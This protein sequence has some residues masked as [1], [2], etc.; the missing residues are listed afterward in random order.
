MKRQL[1][2]LA[3]LACTSS[4]SGRPVSYVGGW[5]VIEASNRQATSLWVHYTPHPRLS[6]G[7][8]SEWDR[9]MSLTFHGAQVTA[10]AKRWFGQDHQG[11][12]YAVAGLGAAA[13]RDD[14]PAGTHGAAFAGVMADW[15]TRRWF[16]SYTA[17]GLTAGDVGGGFYQSARV[18]V[19]PYIGGTD[20][21]HTWLML[22][23]DH[24]PT[25]ASAVDVT[26]LLRFFKGA[27]LF[28][29]GWS[30]RDEKALVNFTYRL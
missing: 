24:R 13:G 16:A 26:P 29:M 20:D 18:G 30:L 6:V 28:E 8:R 19:A 2:V 10:L 7:W 25:L 27:A 9:A 23:I 11:N 1:L 4:A 21:L 14:N 5:T 22:E 17:R 3:L 12:L 15:E